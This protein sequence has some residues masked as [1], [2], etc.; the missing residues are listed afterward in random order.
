[1]TY[2][3]GPDPVDVEGLRLYLAEELRKISAAF[4][5]PVIG[6]GGSDV[7]A[8]PVEPASDTITTI[9]IE[10]V[11]FNISGMGAGEDNI[12]SD[13]TET[14][15]TLDSFI[16]NK[17]VLFSESYND[18]TNKP[19]IPPGVSRSSV[20]TQVKDIII[21]GANIAT[22]DDDADETVS[23]A[24]MAGGVVPPG[25]GVPTYAEPHLS[26]VVGTPADGQAVLYEV[27]TG[28]LVF[29]DVAA[30]GGSTTTDRQ[31]I[32]A[33]AF[34]AVADTTTQQRQ[35]T[36]GAT[37]TSVIYGDGAIEMVA[38]TA[39]E[40]TF[41]ILAAGVYL[42]EWNAVITPNAD[43]PE[44]CLRV[45]DNFDDALL[46]ETDPIYI[47]EDSQG[48]YTVN[49]T[50][51]LVVP[52]DNT[53]V[54]IIVVN[55]RNSNSFSVAEGHSLRIIRG[56]QGAVGG[57]D[58]FVGARAGISPARTGQDYHVLTTLTWDTEEFDV[59]GFFAPASNTRMTVP[60]GV[61]Y[62]VVHGGVTLGG[63]ANTG[64]LFIDIL[65]NG[66]SLGIGSTTKNIGIST[67]A[68]TSV[69]TGVVEVSEGDYFE[70]AI[71]V[72]QD[73]SVTLQP[74]G[75][76]FSCH[77]S[78]TEIG[79]SSPDTNDYVSSVAFGLVGQ[80]LTLT[81]DRTGSLSAISGSVTLPAGGMG[82]GIT[83]AEADARYLQ[84]IGGTLASPGRLTIDVT[85]NNEALVIN[86]HGGTS[87]SALHVF[88]NTSGA[89]KAIQASRSNQSTAFFSI[90]GSLGG[91]NSKPGIAFGGGGTARDTELYRDSANNWKTPD[92]ITAQ[93]FSI[94]GVPLSTWNSLGIANV[95]NG[96][97]TLVGSVMTF[98][99]LDGTQTDFTL[100]T[101]GGAG[102]DTY[103][104]NITTTLDSNNPRRFTIQLTR[105]EGLPTLT[106]SH[107]VPH[108]TPVGGAAGD[109]LAK[110]TAA[111]RDFAYINPSTLITEATV[112]PSVNAIIEQG[113]GITI[114]RDAANNAIR[115][116]SDTAP[117]GAD[118]KHRCYSARQTRLWSHESRCGALWRRRLEGIAFPA[119]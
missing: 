71:R 90:E 14:D 19:T 9:G 119:R 115:I 11:V 3:P 46:G 10:G 37:P 39:A 65:K 40:T 18:L 44:P 100:P 2:V 5:L 73:T 31:R 106:T 116:A 58:N 41:T 95:L 102:T 24:G 1:M 17:P 20:Y 33:L 22:T 114:T 64:D 96:P 49:R 72:I 52:S 69:T 108:E 21:D 54:K 81:L 85:G 113:T 62:A 107:T 77:A 82:G 25:Y 30:M 4:S 76:F 51:I 83:E 104:T 26:N 16:R 47:R 88:T 43:R 35:Q 61:T 32:E 60:S 118:C 80:D 66:V 48:N 28:H 84:L 75:T 110:A 38:A 101:G 70:L 92:W 45:L 98:T 78:S 99:E 8:N 53:V 6:E 7:E 57:A 105:N 42:M 94:T 97:P 103:V 111:D 112:F 34:T 12:Q 117:W 87:Q 89:E 91:G 55:C 36:L 68:R 13:Y 93:G 79:G 29:G 59:G 50:G 67:V 15:I 23:I 74:I 109:L 27:A 63:F 56:A 86:H